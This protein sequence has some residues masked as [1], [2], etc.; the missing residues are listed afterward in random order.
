[1]MEK[2]WQT[3]VE[4]G[5]DYAGRGLEIVLILVLGWLAVYLLVG[6]R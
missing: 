5:V 4:R 2:L 3:L 6:P 1:M